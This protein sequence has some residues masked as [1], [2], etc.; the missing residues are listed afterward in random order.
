[1]KIKTKNN[2]SVLLMVIFT[3]ALLTAFVVGMLEMNTEQIQIMRNE[4]FAAQAIAI[5]E[6]GMADAFAR[7]RTNSAL[8]GNFSSSFGGGSYSVTITGSLPDPNITS[9]G[10]SAQNY[11]A[12]VRA[13]ITV[14]T[15]NSY[16]IRVD[17]LRINE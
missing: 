15:A 2:G 16:V 4:I 5:A 1:M 14:D 3:I 9:V 7:I 6:A 11:Q 13:D 8:P 17:Q 12:R 10:T